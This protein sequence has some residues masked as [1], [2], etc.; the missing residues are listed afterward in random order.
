M[1]RNGAD[2]NRRPTGSLLRPTKTQ[3]DHKYTNSCGL[4]LFIYPP[5]PH[6]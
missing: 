2:P 3:I 4:F 5:P 1:S 6:A